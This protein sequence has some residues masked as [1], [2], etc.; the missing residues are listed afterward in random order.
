MAND[1]MP[2]VRPDGSNTGN[3]GSVS[4]TSPQKARLAGKKAR[5]L[6]LRAAGA[7]F[8]EIGLALGV[9]RTYAQSLVHKAITETVAENA[10]QYRA[11]EGETLLQLQR[12]F[13]PSALR[14]DQKSAVVVLR[15]MER[16]AKLF[17]LDAPTKIAVDSDVDA[18]IAALAAAII[19]PGEV[20][21]A[22]DERPAAP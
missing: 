14:G 6:Q 12:A 15:V 10:D 18:E 2:P 17:G 3:V 7:T 21:E 22:E 9:H 11:V 16:R 19:I 13:M 8:R 5:A 1:G 4:A 20:E